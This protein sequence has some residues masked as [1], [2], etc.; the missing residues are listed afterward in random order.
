MHRRFFLASVLATALAAC[1][2]PGQVRL[3]PG[4][5]LYVVRHGDRDGENLNAKGKDRARALVTALDG[6]PLDAIFSPGLQRNLDT[7]AP[8]SAA[9]G[10]PIE[11]LAQESPAA[12][13]AQAGGGRATIWIG[14]KGNIQSIWDA[15]SLPDP[16]PLEYGDLHIIGADNAGRLTVERRRF[17]PE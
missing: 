6:L 4:S 10:L 7:A 11:R 1:A 3:A 14:N 13:L 9:R 5:T 8:L 17:G 2:N 12:K 15:L 16:A